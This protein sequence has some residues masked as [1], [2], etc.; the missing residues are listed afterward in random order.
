MIGFS[1][2]L[3]IFINLNY[4]IKTII[5]PQMINPFPAELI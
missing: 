1:D 4:F 5:N 2:I 3:I